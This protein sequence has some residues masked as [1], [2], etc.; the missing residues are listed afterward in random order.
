MGILT[1]RQLSA[2]VLDF[3]PESR[4]CLQV[5]KGK[6][7]TVVRTHGRNRSSECP[8]L[9]KSLGGVLQETP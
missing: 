8:A 3:P 1:S 2:A 7:L 6:S 5:A 4:N 9:L